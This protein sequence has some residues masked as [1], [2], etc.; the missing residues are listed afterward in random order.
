MSP[1]QRPGGSTCESSEH[2]QDAGQG[3][4]QGVNGREQGEGGEDW[5]CELVLVLGRGGGQGEEER[6]GAAGVSCS[7]L[8][9]PT[10]KPFDSGPNLASQLSSFVFPISIS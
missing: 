6:H 5:E 2:Q 7:A 1:S 10:S 4:P 9:L 8:V 3:L